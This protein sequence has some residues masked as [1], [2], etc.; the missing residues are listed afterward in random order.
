MGTTCCATQ[1]LRGGKSL[2]ELETDVRKAMAADLLPTPPGYTQRTLYLLAAPQSPWATLWEDAEHAQAPWL[3]NL[4][5][6]VRAIASM[7]ARTALAVEVVDSD[8][9][10]CLL[11]SPDGAEDLLIRGLAEEFDC[12]PDAGGGNL[13]LWQSLLGLSN[14]DCAKLKRIFEEDCGGDEDCLFDMAEVLG[15]HFAQLLPYPEAGF[16]PEFEVR[17]LRFGQGGGRKALRFPG[18]GA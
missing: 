16:P 5:P 7:T 17:I 13:A 14:E 12:A 8:F 10:V 1:I 15:I 9:C 3:H 11:C 4:R 18:G 2:D 6:A